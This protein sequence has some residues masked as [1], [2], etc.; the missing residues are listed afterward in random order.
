MTTQTEL[1]DELVEFLNEFAHKSELKIQVFGSLKRFSKIA[2][3][4][5]KFDKELEKVDKT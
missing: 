1:R 2:S 5:H 4:V 3:L